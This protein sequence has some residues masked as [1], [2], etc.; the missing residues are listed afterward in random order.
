MPLATI[1]LGIAA[2]GFAAIAWVKYLAAKKASVEPQRFRRVEPQAR[3]GHATRT[4]NVE[5]RVVEPASHTEVNLAPK[6]DRW[7]LELL[8][9]IDWKRFEEVVAAYFREKSF[10]C[11]TTA[12]GP[13]GGVDGRLFFRDEPAPVGVVQCKAWG[14]SRRV[15][16]AQVREL[17]GVMAHEKVPRGYF[18]ATG[19]FT[20]DA[21]T[22]AKSNPI[23]L[24][25]G[26]D[27][28]TAIAKMEPQKSARLLAVS[29]EGDFTT[30]SCPSCGEK[31]Y[32]KTFAT[33]NDA[34]V[35]RRYPKCRTR[36]WTKVA[37]RG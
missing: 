20:D 22:F 12:Y 6:L 7:S 25:T 13:D 24:I 29:T 28:L 14:K 33:G 35:C 34:W 10:R 17:L 2:I 15:G 19:G 36:I 37:V 9:A 4:V 1:F 30:P 16:V 21:I 26:N 32:R 18:A 27:F 11:E 8:Q 5:A 3:A 23:M 31:L